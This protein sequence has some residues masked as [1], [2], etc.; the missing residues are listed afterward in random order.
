MPVN[1]HHEMYIAPITGVHDCWHGMQLLICLSRVQQPTGSE[2]KF[3]MSK[4]RVG[5]LWLLL[6]FPTTSTTSYGH[7]RHVT[8]LSGSTCGTAAK[9]PVQPEHGSR[10]KAVDSHDEPPGTWH[11]A[12]MSQPGYIEN[13]RIGVYPS[14]C[15]HSILRRKQGNRELLS[16]MQTS[17]L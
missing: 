12:A 2:Q 8:W 14:V 1:P 15:V 6:L 10:H 11:H 17:R 3:C 4:S 16:Q 9:S 13:I 7:F 5:R